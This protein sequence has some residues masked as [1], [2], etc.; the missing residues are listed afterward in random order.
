MK[1]KKTIISFFTKNSFYPSPHVATHIKSL[2]RVAAYIFFSS[3]MFIL[4]SSCAFGGSSSSE[5]YNSARD[6]ELLLYG[7]NYRRELETP[8]QGR[9][10]G[11]CYL[12]MEGVDNGID[13]EKAY[14]LTYNLGVTSMRQWMHFGYFM[15][16]PD[17]FK[18]AETALMHELIAEG[19]AYGLFMIGMSHQNWSVRSKKFVV[20]KTDR[21]SS[22]YR[23]WLETYERTWYNVVKEFPEIE[24]WEI[25]N[26]VNNPDFM[27]PEDRSGEAW[28]TEEMAAVTAD[29]HFYASRGIHRANPDAVTVLGGIVDPMGLGIPHPE[30][31]TTM[32]NFMEALYDA[33]ESGEHGSYYPDD[34]FQTAA[35]HPYYYKGQADEYFIAQN[36][37]IYE[38]IRRREGKDKKVYLTEFGWQET[39]YP[40]ENIVSGIG[41]LFR[42]IAEQMPYVESLMYFRMFD[43]VAD[44][45][46]IAGI[47]YDP[48]P[49]REDIIDGVRRCPGAPKPAAY[50]FQQACGGIGDLELLK[51]ERQEK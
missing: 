12:A 51:D 26:E 38:V 3:I 11:I 8:V 44:N 41:N 9:L 29:M 46:N 20:G 1:M 23:E 39:V 43:N 47:F 45:M 42:T 21:G 13:Y 17:T 37:L 31:G 30:T 14:Q 6:E 16:D 48:N 25:D 34:F 40:M 15:S 28:S 10:N 2:V 35:W 50:A 4:F 7:E 18:E 22:I 32:V 36:D 49:E 5:S 27:Y 24:Y 19:Q 33:I